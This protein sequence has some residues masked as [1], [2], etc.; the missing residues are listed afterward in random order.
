MNDRIRIGILGY[1]FIGAVHRE[2]LSQSDD[3]HVLYV[4]DISTDSVKGLSGVRVVGDYHRLLD[5]ASDLDAVIN[6]LPTT[7]HAQAASDT[8]DCGLPM[9]LEKP[10]GINSEEAEEIKRKS[11]TSRV[12][13]MIGMTG[14]YHPEFVRGHEALGQIGDL[15]YLDERIHIGMTPF[16]VQYLDARQCGRGIGLT[17]GVHTIDRFMWYAGCNI[18]DVNIAAMGNDL[19]HAD[20]EDNVRGIA[21]FSDNRV[22]MFSF[23]WSPHQEIDCAFEAVGSEGIVKVYGFDKAVLVHGSEETVLYRHNTAVD[24]RE[25]HKPGIKAE[26]EA[27]AKFL[28]GDEPAKHVDDCVKAQE[29][30]DRFY[31]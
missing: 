16:P 28:R 21:R 2:V 19:F 31:K 12:K 1:G 11:E 9:L 20:V 27:F 14:R 23:R 10:M 18:V 6:A 4:S 29:V 5:H 25:R 22:G 15:I 3:Y 26:L 7:L 24:F 17:N 8:A 13:L 30:I